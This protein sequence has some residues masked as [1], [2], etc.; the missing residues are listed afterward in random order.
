MLNNAVM[1]QQQAAGSVTQPS[2]SQAQQNQ[3][4]AGMGMLK[5]KQRVEEVNDAFYE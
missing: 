5:K 2:S 1:G 4:L 3:G